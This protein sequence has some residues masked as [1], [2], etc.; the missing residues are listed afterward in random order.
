MSSLTLRT[1]WPVLSLC[2]RALSGLSKIIWHS[3]HIKIIL[4]TLLKKNWLSAASCQYQRLCCSVR[5]R[6]VSKSCKQAT[7]ANPL[8][9]LKTFS[10]LVYG[11][12]KPIIK[13]TRLPGFFPLSFKFL[14]L[15]QHPIRRL[16][17]CFSLLLSISLCGSSFQDG[18]LLACRYRRKTS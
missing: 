16:L 5:I 8:S 6:Q 9:S 4:H 12:N 2:S 15:L 1:S 3:S 7:K 13:I 17:H 14:V 11:F 10:S 18:L